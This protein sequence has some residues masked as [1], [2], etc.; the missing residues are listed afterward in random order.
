MRNSIFLS[1]V[2]LALLP[3]ISCQ[4]ANKDKTKSLTENEESTEKFD[5]PLLGSFV[6]F[7]G[8]G[9]NPNKITVIISQINGN[10]LEGR[11]VVGGNDR[12]FS[13]TFEEENGIFKANA[14]EPGSDK[15]DGIFTFRLSKDNAA[16]LTGS[17]KPYKPTTK[18]KDFSLERRKFSYNPNNG[19]YPQASLRLLKTEEVENEIKETLAYMRNEI[20]ARHGYCFKKKEWREIFELN[21]WY[22]PNTA[23]VS[24][25]LTSIEKKN[26]QLIK[27][28][29][30]Y[31]EEFGDEF[32]R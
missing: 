9:E 15:Y 16:E 18:P 14:E 4:N 13:G 26:I 25:R 6:G 7:F 8:E 20:F 24:V 19:N 5:H 3:F 22:V 21:D 28:Y 30:K 23:D 10:K 17:W 11:S 27:R 31:A 32:G 29:E 1:L 2:F 12:P